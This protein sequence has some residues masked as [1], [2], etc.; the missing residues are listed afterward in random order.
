MNFYGGTQW[1]TFN[2]MRHDRNIFFQNDFAQ[3]VHNN[4]H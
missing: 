2:E 1:H 4:E 3:N